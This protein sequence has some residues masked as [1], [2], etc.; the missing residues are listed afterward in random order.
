V[1]APRLINPLTQS[2][3]ARL[4]AAPGALLLLVAAA[5]SAPLTARTE[6]VTVTNADGQPVA[7]AVVRADP[8][9]PRHPLNISDYLRDEPKS[10]GVWQTDDAGRAT[11]T[12]LRDRPT[13]LSWLAFGYEPASMAIAEGRQGPFT[14]TLVPVPIGLGG[15]P[16]PAPEPQPAT[17]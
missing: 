10:L 15:A 7:G 17:P 3:R 11:V 14:L 4:A 2:R 6:Q 5:C 1:T 16:R 9:V 12:L 13:Q 8:I